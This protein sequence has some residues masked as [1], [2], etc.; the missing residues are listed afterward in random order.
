MRD[1]ILETIKTLLPIASLLVGTWLGSRLS[2]RNTLRALQA[3]SEQREEELKNT[4]DAKEKEDLQAWFEEFS[5]NKCIDPLLTEVLSLQALL[6]HLIFKSRN[7]DIPEFSVPP[8]PLD[9]CVRLFTLT[10]AVRFIQ[11]V[12]VL[13]NAVSYHLTDEQRQSYNQSLSVVLISLLRL[14]QYFLDTRLQ[15]KTE[16][17]KLCNDSRIKSVAGLLDKSIAGIFPTGHDSL[18]ENNLADILR[19]MSVT[20]PKQ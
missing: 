1:T 13:R 3:Q 17:Y 19:G 4:R 9:A 15:H 18:E 5:I 2:L 16:V 11:L 10:G 20:I 8:P 6:G 7:K 12:T 14:K